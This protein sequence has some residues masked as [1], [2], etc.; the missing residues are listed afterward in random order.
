MNDGGMP[1]AHCVDMIQVHC[2]MIGEP[3]RLVKKMS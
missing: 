2:V 1:L 3:M